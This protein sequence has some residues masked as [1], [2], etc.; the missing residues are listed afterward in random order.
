MELMATYGLLTHYN[1]E[2]DNVRH[3][4]GETHT[5][6]YTKPFSDHFKYRHMVDD[7]NNLRHS[8]PSFEDTWVTHRWQ[9]KVFAF[10]LAVTEINLYLWLRYT[11]WSK[12]ALPTPTL[13]QFRKQFAFAL[14]DN[15]YIIRDEKEERTLPNRKRAHH[16]F[17]TCP[18][19]ARKFE[20][21][22][23][24]LSATARYQQH[25]CRTPG[26]K[27]AVQTYCSCNPGTWLCLQC[28]PKHNSEVLTSDTS[29]Y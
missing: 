27:K 14:I 24:D 4:K 15:Q 3:D 8:S 11:T 26:C 12:S 28:Y 19:H 16:N 22:K 21:G 20:N 5:F 29:V 1:G 25:K 9:N 23:W 2:K 7:H 13:H 17:R 18:C 6:K 10:L